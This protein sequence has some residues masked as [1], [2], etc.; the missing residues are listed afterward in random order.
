MPVQGAVEVGA[1]GAGGGE[2]L[3]PLQPHPH[4][5]QHPL[6]SW[7]AHLPLLLNQRQASPLLK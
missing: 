2:T 1:A 4:R 6:A 3:Q 5:P 7:R